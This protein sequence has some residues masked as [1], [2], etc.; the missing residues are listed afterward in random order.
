MRR[1]VAPAALCGGLL[2]LGCGGEPSEPA[3]GEESTAPAS[4][5]S[6]PVIEEVALEPSRPRPG[7]TVQVRV[8]VSDPDG[9]PIRLDYEWR[10]DGRTIERAAGQPSLHVE[11]LP[12]ESAIEVTVIAHDAQSE[13][14]PETAV[15]RVGNL[16][17]TIVA[18]GMQPTG[19]VSAG[20]AITAT[21]RAN[22]PEGKEVEYTYRWSVNGETRPIEGPTLPGDQFVRG[23]TIVL[24]VV[25]SDGLAESEPVVSPPIPV[26][27]APPRIVS[28]PGQFS[29][30]GIFRYALKTEDPDGDT[31]FRYNLVQGPTGMTVGFDDGKLTWNPAADAAG[32]H[33]VEIEVQDRF[34][35]KSAYR[36]SLTLSYESEK[37]PAAAEAPKRP[38]RRAAPAAPPES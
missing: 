22:D 14:A 15:A 32:S 38:L 11:N 28:E 23:D 34:G 24:E 33:D 12:R 7:E 10:A 35:G 27:N 19:P 1:W 3:T 6:P 29:A 25:A 20:T 18:V 8:N 37:A 21:P 5:N 4:M 9:D 31:A 26:V 36:F 17:P 13:S 30:D 2:L 16:P